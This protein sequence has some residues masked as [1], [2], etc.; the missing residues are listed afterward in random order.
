M[1]RRVIDADGNVLASN[2]I[3][4]MQD[5]FAGLTQTFEI[6]GVDLGDL[7]RQERTPVVLRPVALTVGGI[8]VDGTFNFGE[9]GT[10][11]PGELVDL[12]GAGSHELRVTIDSTSPGNEFFLEIPSTF[13]LDSTC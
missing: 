2:T 12:I 1:A 7:T 9:G 13:I 3:K 8:T 4:D 10:F 5:F 6:D 11:M